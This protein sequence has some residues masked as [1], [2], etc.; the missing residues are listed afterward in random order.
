MDSKHPERSAPGFGCL[1]KGRIL[2][3]RAA[4]VARVRS[5]PAP[6][7]SVAVSAVPDRSH[8]DYTLEWTDRDLD[9]F[10][11]LRPASNYENHAAVIARF[12]AGA[13]LVCLYPARRSPPNCGNY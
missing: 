9:R 7:R 10:I 3:L 4:G 2:R 1:P 8:P 6:P 13:D 11:E 5:L 12:G